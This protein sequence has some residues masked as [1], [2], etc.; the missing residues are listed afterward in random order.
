MALEEE[1]F[2]VQPHVSA[3]RFPTVEAFRYLASRF[4]DDAAARSREFP[5]RADLFLQD[6]FGAAKRLARMTGATVAV[7]YGGALS[8]AGF[9]FVLSAPELRGDEPREAFARL[10]D[11][12]P[13]WEDVLRE[14]LDAP[15][16]VFVGDENPI[17]STVHFSIIAA[18]LPRRGVVTIVGPVRMDYSRA[19]GTLLR[20]LR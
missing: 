20:M 13:R 14:A 12:A 6:P 16:G 8:F 11:E 1:G 10:I 18:R 17:A 5:V 2:L 7:A 9:E 19:L 4:L 15:V 3:G